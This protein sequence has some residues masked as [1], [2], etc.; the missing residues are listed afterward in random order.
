M[1]YIVRDATY[2]TSALEPSGYPEASLPEV[3]FAGRS[4]VGKS[5][6]INCLLNRRNLVKTSSVP[7]KTQMINFFNINDR[8]GFVDL[9]GYGYAK[10]PQRVCDKWK[11]MIEEYLSNRTTLH[12]VVILVDMRRLPSDEDLVLAQYL[13]NLGLQY[14]IVLTKADKM[15]MTQLAKQLKIMQERFGKTAENALTFSAKTRLGKEQLWRIL[16]DWLGLDEP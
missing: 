12:G 14:V 7:G 6:L 15:K 16:L 9:P 4:N 11:P 3:A 5:S 1:E 2:V 13:E 8:F 10:V